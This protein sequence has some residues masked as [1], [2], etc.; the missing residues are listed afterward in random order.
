MASTI[1]LIPSTDK[2][3]AADTAAI[4]TALATVGGGG[5]VLLSPGDWY[6]DAPLDIPDGT[7]LAGIKSGINGH[8]S[9]APTVR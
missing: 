1:V 4:N 8:T 6:T 2:T 3:G 9:M 7:E 5:S